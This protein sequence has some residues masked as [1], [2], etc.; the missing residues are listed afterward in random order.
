MEI[1]LAAMIFASVGVLTYTGLVTVFSEERQ[2]SRRLRKMGD[3]EA[4]Q[5]RDAEPLLRPFSERILS[6]V[7]GALVGLLRTLAPMGYR[8]RIRQRLKVAGNPRGL[9]VDRFISG[10]VV[11]SLGVL[12]FFVAISILRPMS[13]ASWLLVGLPTVALAFYFPDLWLSNTISNRQK[14]IRRALPDMLDMLTISVE[15]G[16][17]FDQAMAKLVRNSSGPLAKEFARMLQEVQAG[18]DRSEALRHMAQRADVPDLNAFITAIIQADVFGV[19]VSTVLR[20]QA[21]E[22]RLKRRQYAEEQ[23]QKAP[24]KLVF[25][26]ILCILPATILVIL[27]PAVVSI[28]RAFGFFE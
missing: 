27:G 9:D 12:G 7:G 11:A 28:G 20:T 24:V 19:S 14:A 5:A 21:K 22:M 15:A 17:G 23:A 6:P 1:A 2:V 4:G 26:L 3:Y 10:K 16:L 13:P 25:P 18:V 8:D